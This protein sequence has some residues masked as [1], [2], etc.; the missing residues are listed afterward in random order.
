MTRP[1]SRCLAALALCA[2]ALSFDAAAQA[3]KVLRYAFPN[4]ETSFDPT[5]V[6]DLY[7]RTITPH[8]F[9]AL[10]T[11]DHLARPIKVKPLTAAGMPEH[12]ADFKT[13]TVRVR[14][15]ITFADD[16]AFKGQ[17]REL[18]A[19]D[20][21]YALKRFAD[22]AKKAAGWASV[23]QVK[24][25]GLNALRKKALD[26]KQPFDYEH[27]VEGLR[28]LDR[29]TIQF[30]LEDSNPR[31]IF[32]MAAS[33]LYG[34]IAREVVEFYGERIG[35]HPV[36]TGPFVLK[37]WRRSSLIVLERNPGYRERSY[38]AEPGNDDAEGQA[39]LARF[40]GRRL[41]MVDRVE[42]SII[43]ESQPY[44]L[45]FLNRSTDFIER[46]PDEFIDVAMP[47]GKLAPHLA[48]KGVQGYRRVASDVATSYFNMED[49][50]VGGYTPPKV[51]LRRAMWL[52]IDLNREIGVARRSQAIAA[53]SPIA[54][55]TSGYD[56]A[57]KSEN[58]DFSLAR[59]KALLDMYGWVDRDGDGWR[60]QP[61]GAPLAL[62]MATQPA[63]R[64]RQLNEL[65]KKGWD[66]LGVR[67]EFKPAKFP[68]NLKA[69]RAGKLQ[70]WHVGAL[71]DVPDGQTMLARLYGPQAGNQNL[72]RFR[73]A[74]LDAIYERMRAMPDGAERLAL[75]DRVKRIAVAWAPYKYH[76][77]RVFS[78]LAQPWLIGYRR[79]LF[80]Q[81]W[82][83]FVDIDPARQ[84]H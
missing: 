19:Q 39:L 31:F 67:V 1:A 57:F 10:Y 72:A 42:V 73:N 34:A 33:D 48:R 55:D 14:P 52:A 51:A 71:A 40:K 75:F 29:Y 61:D 21:V 13:W 47:G 9:E 78:D 58:S 16:P 62:S 46:V 80:W 66:A 15:G 24:Y 54:P 41:P 74:E 6:S 64:F 20:F 3:P 35:D 43:E 63:L 81:N 2:L 37:Q 45:S 26:G 5:Q 7:S 30:K 65:W 8:I 77:H 32:E 79:P 27:E 84:P 12:S 53:Q 11:Y 23:E 22:P 60:E 70:M 82:W 17:P 68:E 76:A 4:A 83:E 18:T 25:L 69:A 38:D 49:P 50:V 28:A 59:A 36:G 56:P 44:W